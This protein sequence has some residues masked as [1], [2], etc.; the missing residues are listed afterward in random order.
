M[1]TT[2]KS[3]YTQVPIRDETR[4]CL[5]SHSFLLL[6]RRNIATK[7]IGRNLMEGFALTQLQCGHCEMPMME[8]DGVTECVVC[9]LVSKKAKKRAH[10]K[11]MGQAMG[12]FDSEASP[13]LSHGAQQHLQDQLNE[14][15]DHPQE[16]IKHQ[17]SPSRALEAR[18]SSNDTFDERE[19]IQGEHIDWEERE[20]DQTERMSFPDDDDVREVAI[21]EAEVGSLPS[22]EEVNDGGY[23]EVNNE[24][25]DFKDDNS[26]A[27]LENM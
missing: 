23:E 26:E 5:L 11:R 6:S 22:Y 1:E 12:T 18:K 19:P 14:H 24:G 13:W 27:E 2:T 10:S 20:F 9:P 17:T 8:R 21:Y 3:K 7:A 16:V 4:R 15:V 25:S